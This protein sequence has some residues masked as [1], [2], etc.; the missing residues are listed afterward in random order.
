[1]IMIMHGTDLK[2]FIIQHERRKKHMR[3][4]LKRGREHD[5]LSNEELPLRI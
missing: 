2:S 4:L 5:N 1:M 3:E